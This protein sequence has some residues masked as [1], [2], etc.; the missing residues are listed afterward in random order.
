MRRHSPSRSASFLLLF[1]LARL[2]SVFSWPHLS[3]SGTVN[4]LFVSLPP[5][6]FGGKFLLCDKKSGSRLPYPRLVGRQ[7]AYALARGRGWALRAPFEGRRLI[8]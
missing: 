4:P 5:L 6:G 8:L 7:E 2:A 3:Y 1:Y